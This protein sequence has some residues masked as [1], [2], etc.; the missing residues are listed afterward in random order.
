[1]KN[2]TFKPVLSVLAAAVVLS[3]C[4]MIPKYE[5]RALGES[6]RWQLLSAG[7]LTADAA[8]DS[9]CMLAV[10]ASGAG[11]LEAMEQE[12]ADLRFRNSMNPLELLRYM[13]YYKKRYQRAVGLS[14]VAMA[15]GADNLFMDLMVKMGLQDRISAFAGWNTAENS[16]GTV[17]A[18]LLIA[19]L[20]C[21]IGQ[22][23]GAE[24]SHLLRRVHG[25][26]ESRESSEQVLLGGWPRNRRRWPPG[27][28]PEGSRRV[29][30]HE[31]GIMQ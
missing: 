4:T 6:I 15:N 27:L 28:A 25:G 11:Q 19:Q 20:T 9:D 10:H 7:A 26:Q 22:H 30:E 5:D 23:L 14:D 13:E 2:I 3:A 18:Q 21:R 31:T 17:I 24:G 1:M 12:K 8:S 29:P 16:N